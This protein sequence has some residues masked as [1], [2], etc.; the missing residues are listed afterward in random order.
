MPST[1]RFCD[2]IWF[3]I[4][5]YMSNL[6]F[7]MRYWL[8]DKEFRQNYPAH[9]NFWSAIIKSYCMTHGYNYTDI[10]A[11]LCLNES[12]GVGLVKALFSSRKCSRSGCMKFYH[13]FNNDNSQCLYHPGKLKSGGYLSCCRN[14]GFKSVGCK[15][16]FHDGMFYSMVYSRRV[17]QEEGTAAVAA[18]VTLVDSGANSKQP[19]AVKNIA[20]GVTSTAASTGKDDQRDSSIITTKTA[21]AASIGGNPSIYATADH[22]AVSSAIQ[23]TVAYRVS[24][25]TLVVQ[26]TNQ[27]TR[28]QLTTSTTSVAPNAIND[29]KVINASNSS[30]LKLPKIVSTPGADHI[31]PR[32]TVGRSPRHP[33][34]DS[35]VS[36]PSIVTVK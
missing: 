3:I 5:T 6:R 22:T 25:D 34:V 1:N 12:M 9:C 20:V 16:A 23:T 31:T 10:M 32:G 17:I 15:K 29:A 26:S 21:V 4:G 27:G 24:S 35:A 30:S 28:L 33:A 8:A 36:L 18:A 7:I 11:R 19:E 13:E 14:K 2:D